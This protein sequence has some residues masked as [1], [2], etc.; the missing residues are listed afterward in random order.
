MADFGGMKIDAAV[1]IT[2]DRSWFRWDGVVVVGLFPVSPSASGLRGGCA[3]A[4]GFQ[5]ETSQLVVTSLGVEV[6]GVSQMNEALA[7]VLNN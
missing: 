2:Q 6:E 3:W 5:L 1:G 7:V 4:V